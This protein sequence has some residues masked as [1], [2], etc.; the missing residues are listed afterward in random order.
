MASRARAARSDGE[1]GRGRHGAGAGQPLG[2]ALQPRGHP[3]RSPGVDRRAGEVGPAQLGVGL[4]VVA[5]PGRHARRLAH[6]AGGEGERRGAGQHACGAPPPVPAGVVTQGAADDLRHR[7]GDRVGARGRVVVAGDDLGR[8]AVAAVHRRAQG[9]TSASGWR[10]GAR[11]AAG[12]SAPEPG[13]VV[14][15]GGGRRRGRRRRDR[16]LRRDRG[17]GRDGRLGRHR[18]LRRGLRGSLRRRLGGRARGLRRRVGRLRG[19]GRGR[20]RRRRAGCSRGPRPARHR[21]RRRARG[22]PRRPCPPSPVP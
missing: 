5:P 17:L 15:G 9:R 18:R 7:R 21:R 3:R 11:S 4:V 2:R 14:G 20:R 22:S 12:W 13:V 1:D 19:R 6:H 8:G 16:R 10:G